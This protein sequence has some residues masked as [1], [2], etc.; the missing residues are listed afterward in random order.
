VAAAE[1]ETA[2]CH[3]Q[4]ARRLLT[5]LQGSPQEPA[6]HDNSHHQHHRKYDAATA[7]KY[8]YYQRTAMEA[9]GGTLRPISYSYGYH[10]QEARR[11]LEGCPGSKI[12]ALVAAEGQNNN[13]VGG[14]TQ[15]S[16]SYEYHHQIQIT[17]KRALGADSSGVAPVAGSALPAPISVPGGLSQ[18]FSY[19]ALRTPPVVA[20]A[21]AAAAG[22]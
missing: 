17:G 7:A 13:P 14:I 9:P 21:P 1:V 8:R 22:A 10:H 15:H 11:A 16:Y 2:H 3:D 12:Q 6:A 18:S 19:R 4:P 20:A 5:N